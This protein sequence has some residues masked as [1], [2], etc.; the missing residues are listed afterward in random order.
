MVKKFLLPYFVLFKFYET[1]RNIN[2]QRLDV[3]ATL[4]EIFYYYYLF[5]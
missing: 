2:A 3:K 5:V 4:R 1:E